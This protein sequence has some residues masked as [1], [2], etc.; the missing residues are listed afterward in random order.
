MIAHLEIGDFGNDSF[1]AFGSS[2]GIV[3]FECWV[4][5]TGLLQDIE[6]KLS[7]AVAFR[8]GGELGK[9]TRSQ[10]EVMFGRV[11]FRACGFGTLFT[12]EESALNGP[13]S[14]LGRGKALT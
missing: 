12:I 11:D 2:G 14:G 7:E 5:P 13:G 4:A 8:I 9:P 6:E 3:E 1:P 10:K